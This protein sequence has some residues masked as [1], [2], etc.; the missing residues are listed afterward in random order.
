MKK[1]IFLLIFTS[2]YLFGGMWLMN[3]N[4]NIDTTEKT[5][6][7]N[8]KNRINSVKY[9]DMTTTEKFNLFVIPISVIAILFLFKNRRKIRYN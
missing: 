5:T 6:V 8:K 3:H 7:Y 4:R 9:K 2:N 1:I